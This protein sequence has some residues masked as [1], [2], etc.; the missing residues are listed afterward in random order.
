MADTLTSYAQNFEDVILWRALRHVRQGCYVDVGAWDPVTD[1]ISLGFYEKGWR[2]I[3]VE[4]EPRAAARLRAARGDED[5]LQVAVG[6]AGSTDFYVVRDTGLSTCDAAMAKRHATHGWQVEET[7]VACVPLCQVLDRARERDV[8]W[9][10]IDVEGMESAVIQGWAPSPVRPWIVV[11]EVMSP[12]GIGADSLDW[13]PVLLGLG[14][15]F[16]YFDGL[17]RFYLSVAHPELRRHFGPGPN[18]F[19]NFVLSGQSNSPFCGKLLG[20]QEAV[21]Q[22][23]P[24]LVQAAEEKAVRAEAHCEDLRR[25]LAVVADG[26]AATAKSLAWCRK[27]RRKLW[28]EQARTR[29]LEAAQHDLARQRDVAHAAAARTE[30]RAH[31]LWTVA[32]RARHELAAVYASHSW[33]LTAPL[34]GVVW[35][36]QTIAARVVRLCHWVVRAPARLGPRALDAALAFMVRHPPLKRSLLAAA[37]LI[38][39]LREHAISFARRRAGLPSPP[40]GERRG[41]PSHLLS[42]SIDVAALPASVRHIYLQLVAARAAHATS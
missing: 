19:D 26:N 24:G 41:H 39:G 31:D 22:Q 32:D 23:A 16:V 36:V 29:T 9:L 8:H 15:K 30:A 25:S 2:G 37:G 34:R 1:S 3:H 42:G 5:V 14:Y 20:G 17:N 7:A 13:E 18:V 40:G 6:S 33:R 28:R 27:E 4:P 11:V 38:P 12:Y 21:R 10:T 35:L